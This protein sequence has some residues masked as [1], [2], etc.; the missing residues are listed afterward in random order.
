MQESEGVHPEISADVQELVS[1]LERL[2]YR[3]VSSIY[4]PE[5]FGNYIINFE[6]SQCEFGIIRDRSQYFVETLDDDLDLHGLDRAFNNQNDLIPPLLS[7]LATNPAP[8]NIDEV[9]KARDHT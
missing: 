2:G 8:L 1:L 3:P 7:W 4:D 9:R 6:G 5:H